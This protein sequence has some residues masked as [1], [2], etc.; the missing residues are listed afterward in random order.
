MPQRSVFASYSDQSATPPADASKSPSRQRGARSPWLWVFEDVHYVS[1]FALLLLPVCTYIAILRYRL[2]EIDRL[3]NRILVYGALT[4]CIV[5]IYLLAVGG[6]GALFQAR[7]NVAVSLLATG[8]VAVLFQPLRSRL[9]RGV[10]RLMYGERDDPYAVISRL[11]R[12]LEAT[13]AL[14]SVL[15]TIAE[16]IA[17]ALKLPY[18]AIL[19]KEGEGFRTAAAYGS[20]TGEP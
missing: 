1:I 8:V 13:I 10:N 7:G 17:Q 4:A 12:R 14:E 5:G 18:A 6:L 15:P 16:T 19:L 11:G 3:I 2:Y 9:Q 20:P